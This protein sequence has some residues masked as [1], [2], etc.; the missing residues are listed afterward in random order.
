MKDKILISLI[1]LAFI[2]ALLI[3]NCIGRKVEPIQVVQYPVVSA[4]D[5]LQ[6]IK[7][8]SLKEIND[9]LLK[10][11]EIKLKQAKEQ[12]KAT[13]KD[14]NYFKQVALVMQRKYIEEKSLN[15]ADS[16]LKS[17]ELVIIAQDSL[18]KDE[19]IALIACE[20]SNEKLKWNDTI[21]TRKLKLKDKAI[22]SDSIKINNLNK[23]VKKKEVTNLIYKV[24]SFILAVIL[25][26]KSI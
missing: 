19:R 14:L 13:E 1:I 15:N 6:L 21:N 11:S 5:S 2:A 10:V 4:I 3:P 7:L 25:I 9:S 26:G 18:L 20:E 22:T 23:E 16:L 17:K 8:D 24:T 12:I